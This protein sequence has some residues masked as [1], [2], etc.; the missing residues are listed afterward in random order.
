MS[1]LSL[2]KL[3]IPAVFDSYLRRAGLAKEYAKLMKMNP[4]KYLSISTLFPV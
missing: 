4:M 2:R 1:I 3:S